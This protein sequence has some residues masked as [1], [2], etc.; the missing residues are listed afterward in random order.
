M[1]AKPYETFQA[2]LFN[3][4]ALDP[5]HHSLLV[6]ACRRRPPQF[7]LCVQN[8]VRLT[9]N[10]TEYYDVLRALRDIS[11]R[12]NLLL[13]CALRDAAGFEPCDRCPAYNPLDAAAAHPPAAVIEG[14]MMLLLKRCVK[15][16]A[17]MSS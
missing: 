11:M 12:E 8:R 10:V 2:E 16:L 6:L 1:T 13:T 14:S 7:R 15:F 4:T 9:N 5:N 17:S 3:Q